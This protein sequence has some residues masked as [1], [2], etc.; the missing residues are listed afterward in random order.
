MWYISVRPILLRLWI[1]RQGWRI[2]T[3]LE[4][5]ESRVHAVKN[6]GIIRGGNRRHV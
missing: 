4:I 5:L 2:S 6:V 3:D 1:T